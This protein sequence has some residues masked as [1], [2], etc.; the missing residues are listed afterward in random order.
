MLRHLEGLVKMNTS[1]VTGALDS[2]SGLGADDPQDWDPG[3]IRYT[4]PVLGSALD[5]YFR[6]EV[7]GLEN[8]PDGASLFVGNHSGG[9]YIA[10]TFV[11]IGRA[12]C[13]ERGKISAD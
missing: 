9:F 12:S 1:I 3:Y 2:L 10:D 7:R 4:L 6:G 13:R 5:V 8:I 11:Q